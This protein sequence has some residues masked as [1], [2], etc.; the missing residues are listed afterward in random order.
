[1]K[2]EPYLKLI[3]S[4]Y[5]PRRQCGPCF[6]VL[7]HLPSFI[8]SVD[9]SYSTVAWLAMLVRALRNPATSAQ[10]SFST[11]VPQHADFTHAVSDQASGPREVMVDDSGPR[12]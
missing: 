8:D 3:F 2:R 12:R 9:S 10:R 6:L 5:K 11:S 1:M 7:V 4:R